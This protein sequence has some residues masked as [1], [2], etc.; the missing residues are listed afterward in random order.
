MPNGRWYNPKDHNA[1]IIALYR[2]C[3]EADKNKCTYLAT[4]CKKMII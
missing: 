2:V 3:T 4:E 1:P